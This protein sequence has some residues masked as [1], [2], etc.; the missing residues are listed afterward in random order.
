[1]TAVALGFLLTGL[2][3]GVYA[4]LYGTERSV[5]PVVA[6]HER[7]S[8][9]DPAAEPSP[10]FNLASIAAFAVGFGLTGYLLTRAND[11]AWYWHLFIALAAGGATY[12][13]QTLLM[14]RWAIPGA[15]ADQ[16]DE[17]YLLQGT[18]A[19]ITEAVPAEGAGQ[20]QYALDGR[21]Y[22]LP[23]RSMDGRAFA[24]GTDVVID[25]VEQGTAYA[26]PWADVEQRL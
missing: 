1:M 2:V 10:A 12:V 8:E 15:R 6:P 7:R 20:L 17:R 14:A 23:A 3:L 21:E 16:V 22:H 5:Q 25:R 26:E 4:M 11:W 9:H 18:L 19:R 13:L 24:V